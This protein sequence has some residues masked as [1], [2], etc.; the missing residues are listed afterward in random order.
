MYNFIYIAYLY[1]CNVSYMFIHTLCILYEKRFFF[2]LY[3]SVVVLIMLQGIVDN[4]YTII[5]VYSTHDIT[6]IECTN[7][8]PTN[9]SEPLPPLN[10]Q[11]DSRV[12]SNT[13][14]SSGQTLNTPNSDYPGRLTDGELDSIS[15]KCSSQPK[16]TTLRDCGLSRLD[17]AKLRAT[18]IREHPE[19]SIYGTLFS[20]LSGSSIG[21][22]VQN[23]K[24]VL[25]TI[26]RIKYK[27]YGV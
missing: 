25:D 1:R 7:M 22:H 3:I 21:N 24:G 11:S 20:K 13:P 4:I 26:A 9:G 6:G 19:S 16:N 10:N 2:M 27:R 8:S 17:C 14:Q 5:E 18:V 15:D 12:E 23:T